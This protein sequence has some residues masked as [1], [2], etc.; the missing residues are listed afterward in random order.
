MSDRDV[1]NHR[2]SSFVLHY[3]TSDLLRKELSLFK[4]G[5]HYLRRCLK[6]HN[7]KNFHNTKGFLL[8]SFTY[9]TLKLDNGHQSIDYE[10]AIT[11]TL[12]SIINIYD[13]RG[14]HVLL[15]GYH[16]EF[17]F[18]ERGFFEISQNKVPPAM[19]Y[20]LFANTIAAVKY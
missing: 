6:P 2:S 3:P 12:T 10:R 19:R 18:E 1:A 17:I 20:L 7:L 4:A 9:H 5:S 8:Y 16:K 15:F 14:D 13:V 11:S